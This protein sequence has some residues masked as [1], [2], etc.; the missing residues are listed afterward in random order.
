[1]NAGLVLECAA[2]SA[3]SCLDDKPFCDPLLPVFAFAAFFDVFS[4]LV[5]PA[6]EVNLLPVYKSS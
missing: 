4:F 5:G 6:R 3:Y 1:M 2:K